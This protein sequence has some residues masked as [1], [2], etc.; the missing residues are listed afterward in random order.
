[1]VRN[2]PQ[3]TAPTTRKNEMKGGPRKMKQK[4]ELSEKDVRMI[5]LPRL[6][7]EEA[8]GQFDFNEPSGKHKCYVLIEK[9]YG[10][11]AEVS[12]TYDVNIHQL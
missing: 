6:F 5:V 12:L 7:Q 4:R 1:M 2:V 8:Y 3:V 10:F 9:N 11:F